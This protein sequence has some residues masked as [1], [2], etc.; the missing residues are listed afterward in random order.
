MKKP[1]R[2]SQTKAVTAE[3][4]HFIWWPWA[5][6]GL[7]LMLV[8]QAYAAALNGGFVWDDLPLPFFAPDITPDIG[9]FVR[10]L[11][12]LLMLSFWVDFRLAPDQTTAQTSGQPEVVRAFAEQFHST[13]VILH[14]LVSALVALI[15]FK[16]LE[17]AGVTV[18][19]R[20]AI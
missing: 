18:R 16:L 10:D 4:R 20:A 11:R 1:N 3:R 19:L 9:R 5:V 8:V 13:N 7:A 6:G 14:T 17:W 15:I 12:P 2:P